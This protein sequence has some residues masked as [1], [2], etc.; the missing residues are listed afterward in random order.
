M[1]R[2]SQMIS[3]GIQPDAVVYQA[4]IQGYCTVGDL[5]KAKGLVSE[6]MNRGIPP[7]DIVFFNSI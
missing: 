3:I 4:L 1:D 5:V 2:F 6:M 7:P